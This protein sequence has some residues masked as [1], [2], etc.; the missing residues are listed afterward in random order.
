[1]G[2]NSYK[3]CNRQGVNLQNIQITHTTQ[4]QKN[5]QPNWKDWN[6]HFSKDIWMANRHMKKMLNITDYKRNANKNIL[7]YHL[8][9]VRMPII[10][11]S[12]NNKCW[13]WCGEKGILLH[14]WWEYKLV[15]PLWKTGWWYLRK[16]NIE[17]PYNFLPCPLI[18]RG[19]YC[20]IT[21]DLI[22]CFHVLY[23]R[24]SLRRMF[25]RTV[26]EL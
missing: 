14:C 20:H 6:S 1:M 18:T 24:K 5:K 25:I 7:R 12:T 4:Y 26:G 15:Q 23:T 9:A 10:H 2:E 21:K 8:T 11:K 3:Q 22:I 19:H 13:R 16:L 17:L